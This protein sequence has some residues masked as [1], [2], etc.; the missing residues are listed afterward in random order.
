MAYS[1]RIECEICGT[2][3]DRGE[4][5]VVNNE[6]HPRCKNCKVYIRSNSHNPSGDSEG[7]RAVLFA[8]GFIGTMFLMLFITIEIFD[9]GKSLSAV[10][11]VV[12]SAIY[13]KIFGSD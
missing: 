11:M 9:L 1:E 12:G 5:R 2:Y 6:P 13:L 10:V 8:L 4:L 7:S 3:N